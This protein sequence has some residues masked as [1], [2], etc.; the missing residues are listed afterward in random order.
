MG[1]LTSSGLSEIESRLKCFRCPSDIGRLP[2]NISSCYNGF[3]ANQW[4]HW[5]TIYS[6]VVLKGIVPD[7]HLRCWLLFVRACF[8][9]QTRCLRTSDVKSADLFILQFCRNIY[10]PEHCTHLN[11]HLAKCLLDYGPLHAFWCYAFESS[12]FS[13][14]TNRKATEV[15]LMKKFC[16]EKESNR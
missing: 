14:H 1:I 8:I 12:W 3:T 10:G 9:L 13:T 15:Q 11:C 2:S 7:S 16:L 5:I 6:A 4:C